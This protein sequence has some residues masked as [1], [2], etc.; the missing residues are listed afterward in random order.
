MN[1]LDRLRRG[2]VDRLTSQGKV[3]LHRL[4]S[5]NRVASVAVSP[6]C[7]GGFNVEPVGS[8]EIH[9]LF[10]PGD[11]TRSIEFD[12]IT[13]P[14]MIQFTSQEEN[15]RD[16][17]Q[18]FVDSSCDQIGCGP[19]GENCKRRQKVREE[20]AKILETGRWV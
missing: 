13:M 4:D 14:Y 17:I 6:Q 16:V 10:G 8:I 9:G 20:V 12:G 3:K 2:L 11:P 5:G 18:A 1:R 7:R 15:P 19:N